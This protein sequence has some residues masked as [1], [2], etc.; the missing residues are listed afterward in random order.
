MFAHNKIT[1]KNP[2]V[3][4]FIQS[5][6]LQS[7][8]LAHERFK[9][10][11]W[12]YPILVK[13][14]DVNNI[15]FE[16]KFFIEFQ[17][18]VHQEVYEK[19]DFIGFLSY[20][21]PNKIDLN[22]VNE[23]INYLKLN[24]AATNFYHFKIHSFKLSES[25]YVKSHPNFLKIWNDVFSVTLGSTNDAIENHFN[26]FIIKKEIF[27]EYPHTFQSIRQNSSVRQFHSKCYQSLLWFFQVRG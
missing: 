3:I 8:K 15:L 19:Y 21:S 4:I 26:Y 6:D 27:F 10:F 16:N 7:Y 13:D 12:A 23:K 9:Q 25:R 11:S 17:K 22:E 18:N 2:E 14:S 5:H 20:S 1:L 24:K